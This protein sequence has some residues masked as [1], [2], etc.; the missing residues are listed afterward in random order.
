M[1]ALGRAWQLAVGPAFQRYG[2]RYGTRQLR[3][4]LQAESHTLGRTRIRRT[5]AASSV[6][7]QS[8]RSFVP[9]T[10]DSDPV[11]CLTLN[12]LPGQPAPTVLN[13]VRV[14]DITYLP[15]RGSNWLHPAT[16]L[17]RYP[18]KIVGWGLRGTMP[19][20]LVSEALRWA[21]T[22]RQAAAG[23]IIHSD[24]GS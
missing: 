22:V 10:T 7:P 24:Q 18:R 9:R 20:V 17:D 16:W 8:P 3:A 12:R 5:L 13:Q 6:R 23:L 2:R 4:E 21:L 1:P 15:K 11:R 19:E 14:G